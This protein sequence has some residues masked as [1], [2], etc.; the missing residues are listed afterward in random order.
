MIRNDRT[1]VALFA[2]PDRPTWIPT[3]TGSFLSG[4]QVSPVVQTDVPYDVIGQEK[5][6]LVLPAL[7]NVER[8]G[9][10]VPVN[11]EYI[12]EQPMLY[13]FC[14]TAKSF[15]ETTLIVRPF[16]GRADNGTLSLSLGSDPNRVSNPIW[17]HSVGRDPQLS[18]TEVSWDCL[19]NLGNFA[20]EEVVSENPLLFGVDALSIGTTAA[21]QL[22]T[23]MSVYREARGL[24]HLNIGG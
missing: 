12:L 10:A 15:V 21:T 8:V 20:D 14:G 22:N 11:G 6:N 7:A 2:N 24:A 1:N 23:T 4:S 9:V 13:R 17:I 5:A 3:L 19:I 18:V 16:V